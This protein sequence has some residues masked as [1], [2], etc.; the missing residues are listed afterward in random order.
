MT[1]QYPHIWTPEFEVDHEQVIGEDW[2]LVIVSK[3]EVNRIGERRFVGTRVYRAEGTETN[4]PDSA[5]M[6]SRTAS[7]HSE[8]A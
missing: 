7:P 4:R 2:P 6:P 5:G 8:P 3:W 1:L